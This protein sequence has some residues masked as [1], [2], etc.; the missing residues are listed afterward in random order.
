MSL[1]QVDQVGKSFGAQVL[2][3]PFSAQ[4]ARGDR[5]ALVGDNGVGK[6]TL[7]SILAGVEEPSSGKLHRASGLHVGY[8]PQV[9]RL[10]GEGTLLQAMRRAFADLFAMEEELRRLEKGMAGAR[11]EDLERYDA[12]LHT[13]EREGGYEA[14][15]K[16][17]SV[18]AGVGFAVEEFDRPVA[19]LSGGEEA[20]AALARVL[21]EEPDL[22]LLDEPTNHLD[23]AALDW[24][25]ESLSEF[26]GAILIVSHDRHLLDRTATKTW[27][28][29]FS[30]VTLFRGG[31][32]QSRLER[33]AERARRLETYKEQEATVERYRDFI[34]RH[35][36]GQKHGQAKDREKKLERLEKERVERPRDAD[37]ITLSIPMGAASG[38]RVLVTE[39]LEIGF[40][41]ALFSCE[42]LVLYRGEKVAVIGENGC[43]KTTLL[44]TIT[45]QTAPVA[46]KVALGHGVRPAVFSQT[47]EGLDGN[48]TVLDLLLSRSG[49]SISQARGLLGRFLFSGDDALKRMKAL[50]GGERSRI[51]LAL[52]SL[53]E[54]NLLLLDEPTNHLD[55]ASQEILEQALVAYEGTVLLVSHDR[56]LL[57]AVT[58][59]VWEVRDERLRVVPRGY[60]AYRERGGSGVAE[61]SSPPARAERE[62]KVKRQDLTPALPRPE[63]ADRYQERRREEARRALEAEIEGLEERLAGLERSLAEA[64][65]EGDGLR[66]GELGAR[67]AQ[68]RAALEGRVAAW[69]RLAGGE[70]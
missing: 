9:A 44:R 56:A 25:E 31:Y 27:E 38:K 65:E 35:H 68:A 8:L 34:R 14:E 57:E 29:A 11:A 37:R 48:G 66:V 39:S 50:S 6:S 59:Q 51:A 1:L 43:G 69:E 41:R 54:G 28:V 18:L 52:L 63:K 67:H 58:T 33:E 2:F 62:R 30:E 70:T 20:R 49:L 46:G 45:G 16:V 55:L 19:I 15:A 47:Q 17:R 10:S 12:L 26:Q 61:P 21:V 22:L 60:R 5:I 24:L 13:F 3:A 53:I 32:T 4:V 36:A 23:F 40:S 7:L 42:D 64:S